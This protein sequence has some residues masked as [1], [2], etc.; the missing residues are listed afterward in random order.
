MSSLRSR[1]VRLLVVKHYL[2][3]VFDLDVWNGMWHGFQ[4]FAAVVPEASQALDN[5]GRFVQDHLAC[6][7][8]IKQ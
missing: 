3:K 6:P 1:I 4:G 2:K 5:V 7:R 8:H